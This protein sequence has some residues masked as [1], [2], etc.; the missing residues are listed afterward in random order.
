[1][2][3]TEELYKVIQCNK[4]KYM[5]KDN[6]I[7]SIYHIKCVKYNIEKET[8]TLVVFNRSKEITYELNETNIHSFRVY[9]DSKMIKLLTI[10]S[11]NPIKITDYRIC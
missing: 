6:S 1:M 3:K 4:S 2:L 5:I 7:K 10:D 11:E 8:L 9:K